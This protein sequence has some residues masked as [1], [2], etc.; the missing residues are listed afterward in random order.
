M[1]EVADGLYRLGRKHHNFYLIVEGGRATVVDAGG[2]RELPLLE[3]GLEHL[4]LTLDNIEALLITHAHSD[5]IGFA[6]RVADRGVS[7][8]VH[9]AEA[10]YAMDGDAGSQVSM[11]DVPLWKPRAIVFIA[12]MLRAGAGRAYR[13][14]EVE[15]VV[16]GERLDLPGRPRVV[17]TPGHTAGHASYLFE[18]RMT[19]CSGDALVTD[20][21]VRG[22]LDPQL[23]PDPFHLD[24]ALA[25]DSLDHLEGLDVDLLLPGHGPPWRGP[26]A[27]AVA[28]ARG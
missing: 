6:R 15:T 27:D 1:E 2:S 21:L 25:R 26:I 9:E 8:R 13:L 20:G 5:H 4:S 16:D 22:G 14:K 23:L 24:A 11:S 7:V 10:A 12:E 17:A 19:L 18:D 28:R 3:A